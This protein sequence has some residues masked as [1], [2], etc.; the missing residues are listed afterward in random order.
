[1]YSIIVQH[2]VARVHAQM[3]VISAILS[4]IVWT[5]APPLGPLM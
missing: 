1:M 2:V 3:P 4:T 5:T